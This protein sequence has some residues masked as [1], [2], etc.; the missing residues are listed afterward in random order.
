[1][2]K[3]M[4]NGLMSKFSGHGQKGKLKFIG[5]PIYNII[6]YAARKASKE[7]L[8]FNEITKEVLDVLRYAPYKPGGSQHKV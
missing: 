6:L 4:T 2:R 3:I 8:S 1:M 7:K 5:K